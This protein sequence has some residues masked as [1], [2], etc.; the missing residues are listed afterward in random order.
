MKW[1]ATVFALVALALVPAASFAADADDVKAVV[2][3]YVDAF[4]KG[5]AVVATELC[6]DDMAIIDEFPPYAWHGPG[7]SLAWMQ[8]YDADAKKNG[9]TDGAVTLQKV[10][11]AMVDGD[12]AYVVAPA[13]YTYK[14]NGKPVKQNGSMFTFALQKTEAGWKIAAWSWAQN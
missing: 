7:T 9:I 6:V 8:A 5:D 11:H 2:A 13:N 12:R 4:N 1:F 14:K 10:K 3:K